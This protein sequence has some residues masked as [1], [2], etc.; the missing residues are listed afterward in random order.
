MP[1]HIAPLTLPANQWVRLNT[2]GAILGKV[3]VV[4][5]SSSIWVAPGTSSTLPTT[6][7]SVTVGAF[8]LPAGAGGG[9]ILGITMA[10][11]WPGIAGTDI[12]G[13]SASGGNVMVSCA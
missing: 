11:L 9:G 13:Y 5:S 6:E 4:T 2:G 10:D 7:P 8:L 3:T 1:T 12:F